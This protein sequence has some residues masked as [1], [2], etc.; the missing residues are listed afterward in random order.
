MQEM[1]WMHRT[2]SFIGCLMVLHSPGLF[3]LLNTET[4]ARLWR[5]SFNEPL[6]SFALD[7]FDAQNMAGMI[8]LIIFKISAEVFWC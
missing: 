3:V 5:K 1:Y 4:G 7:P 2:E 8:K 6:V